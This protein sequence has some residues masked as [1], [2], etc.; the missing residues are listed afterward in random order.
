MVKIIIA[1][2]HRMFRESLRRMLTIEKIANILA[3]AANGVE[4]LELLE[5][6]QPEII[7]MDIAMPEMDGIEATK[8]ALEKHS[9]LK[10]LALSAFNDERY[11]FSMVEAGVKGFLLKNAGIL[12]LQNALKEVAA[13]NCWFSSELLQKVIAN[14]NAK[15]SKNIAS[16]LSERELEILKLVCESLTNEQ[17]AEKLCIS[18]D[19]VK[20]HRSNLLSKTECTN[21]AGL[22]LFAIKNKIIEI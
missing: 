20:W 8:K 19:T 10:V 15:P 21:T 3:E 1:D 17:I 2:D 22:V 9:A 12:E 11:Y 4:L 7:L 14:L 18:Y 5:H 13:G 16:E 6:H